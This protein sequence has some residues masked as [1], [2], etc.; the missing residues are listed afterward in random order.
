MKRI[1]WSQAVALGCVL[2]GS[3][4]CGWLMVHGPGMDPIWREVMVPHGSSQAAVRW[5]W[6]G[7]LIWWAL[8]GATVLLL[9]A[10]WLAL[11][12]SLRGGSP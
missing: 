9:G 4:W 10:L 1:D 11:I 2:L 3:I 7:A 5:A 8:M 6:A 12:R